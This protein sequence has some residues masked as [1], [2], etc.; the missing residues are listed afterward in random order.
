MDQDTR[1]I[2]NRLKSL[3][4]SL[5]EYIMVLDGAEIGR[6]RVGESFKMPISP[7]EHQI[8]LKIDWCRSNLLNFT[9]EEGI[10]V[11]LECGSSLTG[12]R[13]FL[14]FLYI[15]FWRDKYLWIRQ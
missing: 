5:R 10:Q 14:G 1:V 11:E 6:I 13:I 2:I 7:G 9:A 4:D 8:F 15:S 3:S 12:W